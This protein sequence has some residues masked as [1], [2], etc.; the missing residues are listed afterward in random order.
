MK[1]FFSIFTVL[2]VAVGFIVPVAWVFAI[3]TGIIAIIAAPAGRR[4]D[5]KRRTGGLLGGLWDDV[6]IG[7]KMATCPHCKSKIIKDASKCPY[8]GEWVQLKE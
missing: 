2:L 8:C 1:A 3:V 4:A 6:V 7:L 5:G